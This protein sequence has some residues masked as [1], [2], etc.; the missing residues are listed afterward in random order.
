MD[1]KVNKSLSFQELAKLS[2]ENLS[3]QPPV[4]YEQAKAQVQRVMARIS[5]KN[6]KK[7]LLRNIE[8]L[9]K[10]QI[11]KINDIKNCL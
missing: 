9:T 8:K 1:K 5:T 10:Y 2:M 3:K 4:T 7:G 11:L 6:K